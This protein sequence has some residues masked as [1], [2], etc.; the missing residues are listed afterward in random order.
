M[1]SRAEA[2]APHDPLRASSC[3][4]LDQQLLDSVLLFQGGKTVFDVVGGDLGL[5]LAQG[6][7]VRDL[8][9][10]AVECGGF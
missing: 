8:A 10:H 6:F 5:R 1:R 9:L 7:R 4:Q 2:P 3:L